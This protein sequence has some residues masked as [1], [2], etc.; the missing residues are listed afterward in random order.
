MNPLPLTLYGSLTCEDTALARAHLRALHIPFSN[1]NREYDPRVDEILAR[2]NAGNLVTP[3]LVFGDD[4]IVL[5]EPSLESLHDTLRAAGY[6]FQPP[7]A[8][9]IRGDLKNQRLPNFTLPSSAGGEVTLYALPGRKRAVLFFVDDA[10]DR[11]SQGYARQLT[12]HRASFDEYNAVP[13]PILSADPETTARWAHEFAR[14][15][16][17]LSDAGGTLKQKYAEPFGVAPA[18]ALLAILDSFCAPRAISNSPDAGGL[19][20]PAEVLAWLRLLDNECDE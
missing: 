17:C 2:H 11:T 20:A 14:G 15:Y 19:I 16:P 9:E 8:T 13:L 1:L 10:Y 6:T 18:G 5:A 12:N 3:T 4:Q 7:R